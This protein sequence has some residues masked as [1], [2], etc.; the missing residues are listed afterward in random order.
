MKREIIEQSV[1]LWGKEP[2]KAR[3]SPV[4]R[5]PMRG[6]AGGRRG[7]IVLVAERPAADPGRREQG[8]EPDSRRV[9]SRATAAAA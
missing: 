4:R 1:Q 6:G 5:G 9:A 2:D 8:G 7:R 3:V